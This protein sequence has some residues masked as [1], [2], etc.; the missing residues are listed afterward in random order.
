MTSRL[1]RV[2][3]TLGKGLGI[4]AVFT[5]ALAGGALLHINTPASR[6]ALEVVVQDALASVFEGS[7]HISGIDNVGLR[8]VS[9]QTVIIRDPAGTEVIAARGVRAETSVP[10]LVRN[11]L[12]SGDLHIV[13][14]LARVDDANV[15]VEPNAAGRNSIAAAFTPRP[16]PPPTEPSRNVHFVLQRAEIGTGHVTGK[17][18][19]A[20]PL[21]ADVRHLVGSVHVEPGLV[22]VDVEPTGVIDRALLPGEIAGTASYHLRVFGPKD[23]ADQTSPSGSRMW[24]NFA[25]T[26]GNIETNVRGLL[27]GDHVELNAHVPRAR[28]EHVKALIPRYPVI[29]T[30]AATVDLKGDL[31]KLAFAIDASTEHHGSARAE[32]FVSFGV[33]FRGEVQFSTTAFDPAVLSPTAPSIALTTHGKITADIGALVSIRADVY[34]SPTQAF[35]QPIPAVE[36]TAIF[37]GFAWSGSA[38]ISEPGAPTQLTFSTVAPN[39]PSAPNAPPPSPL[40][41]LLPVD[42]RIR[43]DLST[44]APSLPKVTRLGG[45]FRGSASVNASGTAHLKGVDATVRGAVSRFATGTVH[46]D[47]GRIQGRVF[48]PWNNLTVDTRVTAD[49]AAVDA[50]TMHEASVRV[51]GSLQSPTVNAQFTDRNGTHIHASARVDP[52][53]RA[54]TN[55]EFQFKNQ[56]L[57]AQG[58][59]GRISAQNGRISVQG[60]SLTGADLGQVQ[61]SIAL[62][63]GEINGTLRGRDIDLAAVRKLLGVPISLSGKT[64]VDIALAPT[65]S[66]R[67]GH[68]R[69]KLRDA[70]ASLITGITSDA[71]FD[72]DGDRV[73]GNANVAVRGISEKCAKTIAGI[74]LQNVDG[75]V[76]GPLISAQTWRKFAGSA[77]VHADDWDLSCIAEFVPVGLP[78][79]EISGLLDVRFHLDRPREQTYPTLENVAARTHYLTVSV[80]PLKGTPAWS[81]RDI[82]IEVRGHF[83]GET[84]H[85]QANVQLFD[86]SLL[87]DLNVASTLPLADLATAERRT[88]AATQTPIAATLSIP[89]R[90]VT[91]LRT[92][93][94]IVRNRIPALLG[95]I[96]AD[97]YFT[98]TLHQPSAVVRFRGWDIATPPEQYGVTS[99]WSV[100]VTFDTAAFYNGTQANLTAF[101][102]HA[103]NQVLTARADLRAPLD[104]LQSADSP[105]S[106]VTGNASASLASFPL[107]HIPA[108]ADYAVAGSLSADIALTNIGADP[109][110][111]ASVTTRDLTVGDRV[112]FPVATASVYT[113][114]TKNSNA[115]EAKIALQDAQGGSFNAAANFQFHLPIAGQTFLQPNEPASLQA[116]FHRFQAAAVEPLL[117]GS[118]RQISGVLNGE[119]AVS[120]PTLTDLER[121]SVTAEVT[122]EGAAAY[123]PPLGQTFQI[124][125]ENNT[126]I[127]LVVKNNRAAVN[128]ILVHGRSGRVHI[129]AD[130]DLLGLTL[131]S[132]RSQI[133]IAESEPLPI[134]LEGSSLGDVWGALN[135]TAAVRENA[136]AVDVTS[137]NLHF[138]LASETTRNVQDL[139]QHPDIT[140]S[141]ATEAPKER[142][143]P[144]ARPL[145][146]TVQ[147]QNAV[148][149]G[150]G[151]FI[152]LRTEPNAPAR[153]V[154]GP[155]IL[156]TG[157]IRLQNGSVEI[158]NRKFVLDQGLVQLSE[159]DLANPYVNIG[160]HW[161]SPDGARIFVDLIGTIRPFSRDKLRFRSDP[162][163]AQQDILATLLF[164][165]ETGGELLNPSTPSRGV[166][167]TVGETA[168]DI[169][170]DFAAQQVNALLGTITPLKGLSTRFGASES[171]GLKG[172]LVYQLGD[173]VTALASYEGGSL[174]NAPTTT[175]T[176]S[177]VGSLS[178]DWRFYKNWLIR[179]KVGA[180]DEST[181]E[182]R[183]TG[184][185]EILWQFRY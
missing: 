18:D 176:Q 48:G 159:A 86:D 89:R 30:V 128:P 126:P 71:S 27:E 107:A 83:N 17:P 61:G 32:G 173:T 118:L 136:L 51:Q 162:P 175:G 178:V 10:A 85:T 36:A 153:F 95:D 114:P 47:H 141:H 179:A 150:S 140:F 77:D 6:R 24:A 161:D 112:R 38:R 137:N 183:F 40:L 132:A 130:A 2:F 19:G 164:G 97:L 4:T 100:P 56:G 42:P 124:S 113:S 59:V 74:Q 98:G 20:R 165:S 22:A 54:A 23:D 144:P 57:A 96:A 157:Q 52:R 70:A 93:P 75:T 169:G 87:A 119:I 116:S 102:S 45:R 109:T 133:S 156:S 9:I 72:F 138:A 25:G 129:R 62:V 134:T 41:A 155:R 121:G 79:S 172:S 68:I 7:V 91:H 99:P 49:E 65:K 103:G 160:A 147:L 28:P 145:V 82:D 37:D 117:A 39:A 13:L 110:L 123:V 151:I 104:A 3:A 111:R 69:V 185:V 101:A 120:T 35:G 34:T 29:D 142:V 21:N 90:A 92:L 31:P 15:L 5:T 167:A 84:G 131:A 125:G 105:L 43:F 149:T 177:S 63:G 46:V 73:R 143:P 58:Q 78:I 152:S 170:G 108:L 14:P 115:A 146:V 53:A 33:P 67:K 44:A 76:A 16:K 94:D 50:Y 139:A 127:T 26:V 1:R 180:R 60:I 163:R 12:G 11:I 168:V 184:T 122:L 88:K 182:D 148:V 80:P 81:S 181:A 64:D 8:G 106:V 158:A 171:G 166:Q 135:L 55:I 154:L 66:G 174:S